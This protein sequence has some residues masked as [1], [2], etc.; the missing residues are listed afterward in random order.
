[1][2]SRVPIHDLWNTCVISTAL[3]EEQ[4]SAE[5]NPALSW[6]AMR[7][8]RPRMLVS[9]APSAERIWYT[10]AAA[11][12][13]PMHA[14]PVT[15][16]LQSKQKATREHVKLSQTP[17]VAEAVCSVLL[18]CCFPLWRWTI[19]THVVSCARPESRP[20]CKCLVSCYMYPIL[21][22]HKSVLWT[23]QLAFCESRVHMSNSRR[24]CLQQNMRATI[25][26]G[27]D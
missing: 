27:C 8:M 26:L 7:R 15:Y 24:K 13:N 4:A 3:H 25:S 5:G 12:A 19:C 1:M 10:L 6:A 14:K 16:R 11:R 17:I 20:G 2:A 23:G 9:S 22:P 21:S 18:S